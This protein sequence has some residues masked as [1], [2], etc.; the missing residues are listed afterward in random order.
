MT[1]PR[2]LLTKIAWGASLPVIGLALWHFASR[3]SV[4]VPSIPAV[5]QVLAHPLREPP[6]LDALPLAQSAAISFARVLVGF[7]LAV[8]TGVPLGLLVGRFQRASDVVSPSFAAAMVISPVAWLPVTIL[9]F[10]LASPATVLYGDEAWQH[11]T[12]DQ[13]RFAI[14][15]VIWL[16]TL[17]PIV[18]NTAASARGVR[19]AH[20]EAARVLGAQRW[21]VLV[22]VILPS[23]GPGILTGI[24]VGGGIAWRVII[25]AEV[26]P[27]TRGGLGHMITNAHTQGSYEYAFA[28]ILVIGLIGL[29]LDGVLR[30][31]VVTVGHWQHEQR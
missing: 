11:G 16:G 18:L 3:E 10:G 30:L 28:S 17:C 1:T 21:Q 26:F 8:L 13:V 2:R 20:I 22:K 31:L 27:G 29:T 19:D 7:G 23:A 15:A 14:V 25:A 9:V 12:L 5:W 4:I 6:T 24:R